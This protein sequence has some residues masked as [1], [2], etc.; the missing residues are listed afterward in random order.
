MDEDKLHGET[1][2]S[3]Y[4]PSLGDTLIKSCAT[5]HICQIYVEQ[6]RIQGEGA[7]RGCKY[8]LG[9]GL[10]LVKCPNLK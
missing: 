2:R 10:V 9:S 5:G 8:P 4:R 6:V 1:V 3:S 7:L